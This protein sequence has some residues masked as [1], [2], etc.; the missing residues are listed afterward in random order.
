[1][2]DDGQLDLVTASAPRSR[3]QRPAPEPAAVLPVARVVVDSPLAHLDR[4]FD[5][6]VPTTLDADVVPGCRVR[7]RF[8]GRLTDAFVVERVETSD[9]EGSL[10]Y[11]SKVVSPE[12]V[13]SPAVLGLCRAVADRWAGTLN[14]VLRLAIPPRHDRA[15]AQQ[16]RSANGQLRSSTGQA[17]SDWQHGAS[18]VA[19][20]A[21][22][23]RPRACW[24]ALPAH[25][26][27]EA[28]AEAVLAT[29]QAGRGSIVCVPDVRDV[30]RWDDVFGALLGE[31][32]H[33]VL[34][35]SQKPAERYRAF[36]AVSRGDIRVVL[37]TRG[38]AFAPVHDLGLV[39]MFDDGD[40]LFAEPRAPYPHTREILLI[41]AAR[42]DAAVLIGGHARSVES[43]SLVESGW[44]VDLVAEPVT[45]RR[46][47]PAVELTDGSV[48][49]G[50]PARLPQTVFRAIRAADGPVLAQ[51]PRRGYRTSLACQSCRAPAR[52]LHCQGPLVQSSADHPVA[53]RWC[54]TE[55]APWTC[56]ECG[57]DRLRSPVVGQ[58]RTAEEYARAFPDHVVVTSGGDAVLGDLGLCPVE[59]DKVIVLATPG[60]E[61]RAP[62]GYALVVL[63]DTWLMLA[64]DDVRV[65]EESHRRWFNALALARETASAV[66][67]G[68]PAAMQALVR[69][70]PIGLAS[71]ELAIRAETHLPPVG[72][73]V[74]VDGPADV[75][76]PLASRRWTPNTE[77]LGPVD[78]DDAERLVLRA[79]RREGAA[80]AG[81]LQAVQAERSADKLPPV[82]VR[83]DP[84]S[85]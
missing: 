51:V 60:A 85:F 47:W 1:M 72:R 76:G 75:L 42:E 28:V 71:R 13:L 41:R 25:E 6:L 37:G 17:W 22:G 24:A 68:D 64:R 31:G 44:C 35:G 54:G 9:H 65:V 46:R 29:L 80:L 10:A 4:P 15:E 16:S 67:V 8:S 79:P 32:R 11:L 3:R 34:T 84:L 23:E 5:Y 36:L 45:R 27:A 21:A 26:P 30:A 50:A 40:D 73:L 59:Q 56:A 57:S 52:C 62:G 83:V 53:C 19:A 18:F 81:E 39:A 77:V 38:A 78:H 2:D 12:P 66:A 49:G 7:V 63:M 20:L 33:V 69:A 58:L 61:P 43:Q 74:T 14:D 48:D 82:R 55:A 70:D